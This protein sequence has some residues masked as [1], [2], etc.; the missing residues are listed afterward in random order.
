MGCL[1]IDLGSTNLKLSLFDD[2]ITCVEE[3]SI[4]V[5]YINKVHS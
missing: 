4:P 5:E 2:D 1:A 3:V